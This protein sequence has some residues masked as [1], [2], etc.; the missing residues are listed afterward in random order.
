MSKSDPTD[1]AEAK[2]LIKKLS[3]LR[4]KPIKVYNVGTTMTAEE[5][6]NQQNKHSDKSVKSSRSIKSLKSIKSAPGHI[7][8]G[9]RTTSKA[10]SGRKSYQGNN[11]NNKKKPPPARRDDIPSVSKE[12]TNAAAASNGRDIASY[13]EK[14]TNTS[15]VSTA[16]LDYNYEKDGLQIKQLPWTQQDTIQVIQQ[17][18]FLQ[19][20]LLGKGT[21]AFNE[22]VAL[23][24][25]GVEDLDFKI[26]KALGG[27]NTNNAA[28]CSGT[29]DR[30]DPLLQ[31]LLSTMRGINV[32]DMPRLSTL[33]K[34]NQKAGD[35]IEG[36]DVIILCGETGSG[37]TTTL[38]F[39]L[40]T[41]FDEIEIDG[42]LHYGP[43]TFVDPNH[44][45]FKTSYSR[46]PTTRNLQA[47]AVKMNEG[48]E[49]DGQQEIAVCDVPS[50][51]VTKCLE[52]DIALGIG[53]VQALQRAKSVR[54]V[55]VLSRDGMGNRFGNLCDT[56]RI[57]MRLCNVTEN[58]D[59]K[60]FHYVFTKYDEK[61][62]ELLHKQFVALRRNPPK[63]GQGHL[64]E[65]FEAF[66]GDI[67]EK[68][69]VEATVIRPMEDHPANVLPV[70]AG[71]DPSCKVNPLE[72]CANFASDFSVKQLQ[73]QMQV[74][75]ND[76]H[77]H[78]LE[79]NYYSAIRAM[80]G[81][82]VLADM[83][84]DMQGYI[85]QAKE[86]FV[87][88]VALIWVL[89]V[90][91]IGKQDYHT[92]LY[93]ME[94]LSSM[95]KDFP[96]AVE[97]SELGREMLSQSIVE[98]IT[99]KA[100]GKSIHRMK[101][102]GKVRK[103]FPE[104]VES[105]ELGL[106][107]LRD[108]LNAL[109]EER[110]FDTAIDLITQL[111]RAEPDIPEG[112][113]VAQ[114]GL[115]LVRESLMG[116]VEEENYEDGMKLTMR[117]SELGRDF[118][119]ANGYVRKILKIIR[120]R[121]DQ[122]IQL[123]DYVKAGFLL[124][125]LC[126]LGK[127]LYDGSEYVEYAFD[128]AAQH[129]CELRMEVVNAFETLLK[130]K[131]QKKYL[132]LLE[133]ASASMSNLMK[134]E[135][136]RLVCTEFYTTRGNVPRDND[137]YKPNYLVILCT[138]K[139]CTSEAFCVAQVRH[140]VESVSTELDMFESENTSME[141]LMANRKSLLSILLRLRAAN[142]VF[143]DGPGGTMANGLYEKAFV[144]FQAL[145]EGIIKLSEESFASSMEMKEFEFQAWFLAFLIQ[146]F[147]R[148]SR[149]DDT[150]VDLQA[151]DK[152]DH[153]RVT[154]ML[155]FENEI[156]ETMDLLTN[157]KFPDFKPASGGP[158]DFLAYFQDIKLGDLEAPRQLLLSLG[159]A[160][161]LCKMMATVLS[162][163]DAQKAVHALDKTVV[164][165]FQHI[166]ESLEESYGQLVH[167][168]KEQRVQYTTAV[169]DAKILS[170]SIDATIRPEI[171]AVQNWSDDTF[172][173]LGPIFLRLAEIE[174]TLGKLT[175]KL[176]EKI[177]EEADISPVA[178]IYSLFSGRSS[179]GEGGPLGCS[180]LGG[181]GEDFFMSTLPELP[182]AKGPSDT[183]TT[184][185]THT[186]AVEE[187]HT[188][189][190]ASVQHTTDGS[191]SVTESAMETTSY[192]TKST[193]MATGID[194][195][196]PSSVIGHADIEATNTGRVG[197][198]VVPEQTDLERELIIPT[199]SPV[200]C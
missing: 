12:R 47:A 16:S 109:V 112:F 97:C 127:E 128:T 13:L 181:D 71:D 101:L 156:S 65:L 178:F 46:E 62:R 193:G 129:V 82:K 169:R 122:S 133:Y 73:L 136:M 152:L 34:A 1:L 187:D 175:I 132:Q 196:A 50:Y 28:A 120:K 44:A 114:H 11:T 126:E 131:D 83:F 155:R 106:E 119:E 5:S 53:M 79:E 67:A 63:I 163:E 21:G 31:R 9:S 102:L 140:L 39:L 96:D 45:D 180:C 159:Q 200:D 15:E 77:G 80:E 194:P 78:L 137:G 138:P 165:L 123:G 8:G 170:Q 61:H 161:Q 95:A 146:G 195:A 90:R 25:E 93:R 149:S 7:S 191:P 51:D 148:D 52:E 158:P 99:E 36:K 26:R 116:I 92:A 66:V 74:H 22:N 183:H 14:M 157:Y 189:S 143:Q 141:Y 199:R 59:W 107:A 68:T 29:M 145:I 115:H 142:R 147:T 134:S 24:K 160:Q 190:T 4:T 177:Q 88:Q 151:M 184:S 103:R 198:Y 144:K 20:E 172:P 60:P 150:S 124:R 166:V 105:I 43:T 49:E 117:V 57:V 27:G 167:D 118:A 192:Y 162:C 76:F 69:S 35:V 197:T 113:S 139:D 182:P 56:M 87:Q 33:M 100:Y 38:Q 86:A 89:V 174:L 54:P 173:G 94:Q 42:F 84:P 185:G 6:V 108:T 3:K 23:W 64:Q 164:Q 70:L 17:L 135:P 10:S 18:T 111:G 40:G 58:E 110:D 171:C 188:V 19:E 55:V 179:N 186:T 32:V 121:I 104:A 37:K 72:F 81:I 30:E 85:L 176:E 41:T 168:I 98:P 75:L 2:E 130:V 125:H 91:S 153:R 154:L 48:D